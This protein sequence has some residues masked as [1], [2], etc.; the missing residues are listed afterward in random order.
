MIAPATAPTT[1]Q[2]GI[3]THGVKLR[4]IIASAMV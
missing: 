3:E 2:N 4:S 1:A